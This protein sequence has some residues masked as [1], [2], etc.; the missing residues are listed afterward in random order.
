MLLSVLSVYCA[1][2]D[3]CVA[4][5]IMDAVDM[6]THA[7]VAPTLIMHAVD[8]QTHANVAQMLIV[9][10]SPTRTIMHIHFQN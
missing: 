9:V 8:M 4:G 1:N 2:T 3:V 10:D 5:M 6:Q 7:D